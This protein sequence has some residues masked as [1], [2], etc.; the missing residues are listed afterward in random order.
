MKKFWMVY[1]EEENSPKVRHPSREGA[2]QEAK[3][4]AIKTARPVYLLEAIAVATVKSVT[5]ENLET[6]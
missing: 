2:E 1:V 6:D 4:L 5:W 3:R